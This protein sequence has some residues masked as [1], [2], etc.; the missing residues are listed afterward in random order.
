[1]R[2]SPRNRKGGFKDM[3][4]GKV[5]LFSAER[6]YGFISLLGRAEDVFGPSF[7][8]PYSLK[9]V[10][11]GCSPIFARRFPDLAPVQ[12]VRAC[13]RVPTLG[14]TRAPTA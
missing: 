14:S 9:L 4:Q 6:G 2:W 12:P 8:C 3:A 1:L 10:E 7:S 11:V 5:K 13:T